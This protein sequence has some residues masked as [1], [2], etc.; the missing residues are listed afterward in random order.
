MIAINKCRPGEL[1]LI[2]IKYKEIFLL[3]NYKNF[4][5]I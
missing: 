5:L 4:E 3:L 2:T 1:Y